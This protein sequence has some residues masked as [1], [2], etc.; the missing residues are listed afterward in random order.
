[1]LFGWVGGLEIGFSWT[2]TFPNSTAIIV[3]CCRLPVHRHSSHASPRKWVHRPEESFDCGAATYKVVKGLSTV[4]EFPRICC[5]LV[6]K[7]CSIFVTPWTTAYQASLFPWANSQGLLKLMSTELVMPSNYL[8]LCHPLLLLPSVF[9]S[10]RVFTNEAAL[11]IRCQSI[12]TSALASVL[13]MN[14]QSLFPL[15]LVSL[16]SLLSQGL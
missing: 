13:S 2:F 14:I 16:I 4:S 5:C 9:P 15:E 6:T 7:S 8:I 12:E 3:D 1:M 10:I 11:H